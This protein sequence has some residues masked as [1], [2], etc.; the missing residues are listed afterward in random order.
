MFDKIKKKKESMHTDYSLL[1]KICCR[2][3]DKQITIP[4]VSECELNF[5]KAVCVYNIIYIYTI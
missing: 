4:D 1:E 3:Y 2:D 5:S